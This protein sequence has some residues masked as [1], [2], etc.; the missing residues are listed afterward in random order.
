[1]LAKN[2]LGESI[3]ASP[4]IADGQLFLRGDKHLFCIGE[5]RDK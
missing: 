5:R 4:A 1:V 3:V 2:K